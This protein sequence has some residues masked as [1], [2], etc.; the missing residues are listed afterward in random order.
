VEPRQKFT[1]AAEAGVPL[2]VTVA[3]SVI[4]SVSTGD[5]GVRDTFEWVRISSSG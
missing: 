4:G 2:S 5:A 3:R 1:S